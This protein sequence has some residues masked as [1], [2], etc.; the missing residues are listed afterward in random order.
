MYLH[1]VL[2]I[3]FSI[4]LALSTTLVLKSIKE[5]SKTT[6]LNNYYLSGLILAMGTSLPELLIAIQSAMA[7]QAS[8]SLGNVLGSNIANLSIVIGG[9]TLLGGSLKIGKNV[10]SNDIYYA[11]L[12]SAAPLMLL[13]DG[14]L[15]RLDGILLLALFILWQAI[16]L[17]LNHKKQGG[18]VFAFL[19]Q[20]VDQKEAPNNF[21]PTFA[22]LSVGLTG[23]LFASHQLV[24]SA[25]FLALEFNI[26]PLIVGVFIIGLGSSMPELAL[27]AKAI[28][29]KESE[30]ALGDLLGSI[31]INSSLIA[32]ITTIS[33]TVIL[34]QPQLYL[35]TTLFFLLI[36]FIFYLFIR[37]KNILERWEGAI[38]LMLYFILVAV[39]LL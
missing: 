28:K 22:R 2:L 24:K 21:A 27:E 30:I 13:I 11:F 17:K 32:G 12:I 35:T 36:F 18:R 38:L 25:R 6:G 9:A 15:S 39:E 31:V 1:F 16:S 3:T 4:I 33:N 5:L 34:S 8:L 29:N 20:G 26:S 23:L 19:K 10:I 14:K 7:N 37:T